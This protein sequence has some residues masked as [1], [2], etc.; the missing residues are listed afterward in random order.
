MSYIT[1]RTSVTGIEVTGGGYNSV[2]LEIDGLDTDDVF[3]EAGA[4]EAVSYFG[5]EDLLEH[6]DEDEV[7]KYFGIEEKEQ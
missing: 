7:R 4:Q 1:L 3:K 2:D 5:T 6:M